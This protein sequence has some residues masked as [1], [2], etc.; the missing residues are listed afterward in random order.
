MGSKDKLDS[1]SVSVFLPLY[2]C[3]SFKSKI[4]A[5][6]VPSR[7]CPNSSLGQSNIEPYRE[8]NLE[9]VVPV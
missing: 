3:E 2:S 7:S 6:F 4:S 5:S 8:R 9:N 1:D